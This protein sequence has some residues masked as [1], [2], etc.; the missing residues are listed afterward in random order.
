MKRQGLDAY[1][2]DFFQFVPFGIRQAPHIVPNVVG[3]FIESIRRGYD[4]L[5][6]VVEQ[7][8]QETGTAKVHLVGYSLGGLY[9]RAYAQA[10]PDAVSGCFMWVTPHRGTP[11]ALLGGLSLCLGLDEGVVA[12]MAPGSPYLERL[13]EEFRARRVEYVK[14]NVHFVNFLARRD[15]LVP[16]PYGVLPFADRQYECRRSLHVNAI[17]SSYL[18][19]SFLKDLAMM[20]RYPIVT[21]HGMGATP[22]M[23]D[24]LLASIRSELPEFLQGIRHVYYDA[25]KKIP[26][27]RRA[28]ALA[29]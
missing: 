12:Q 2:R 26:D 4:S 8:M 1:V 28:Y 5:D 13:N 9:A 15:L 16:H 22:R 10:R 20:P 27:Y 17:L 11:L 6:D 18:G 7:V 21:L 24:P 3:Q 19:R 23:F 29:S 14:R 25:R